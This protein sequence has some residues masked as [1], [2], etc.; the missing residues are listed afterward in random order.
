MAKFLDISGDPGFSDH[1]YYLTP[2]ERLAISLAPRRSNAEASGGTRVTVWAKP[3]HEVGD[4]ADHMWVEFDDGHR[5]YIARGGPDAH[6]AGALASAAFDDLGV[7]GQ[8]DPARQSPDFGQGE[9]IVARAELP[10]VAAQDAIVGAE[11]HAAGVNRRSNKYGWQRNSN[12]YAA[13]VF[14]DLTGRRVGDARTPGAQ[15]RL[16][17]TGP[18][19]PLEERAKV[20]PYVIMPWAF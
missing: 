19:R 12:S 18:R 15:N 8:V 17:E 10:G 14:E 3:V 13:D 11:R 20:L 16:K 4:S 2:R 7:M 1:S 6:G 5:Q 9:R